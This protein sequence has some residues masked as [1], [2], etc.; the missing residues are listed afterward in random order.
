[1]SQRKS[2][3]NSFMVFLTPVSN[4]TID[5][6]AQEARNNVYGYRLYGF[7]GEEIATVENC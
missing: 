3:P 6:S 5:I 1:M 4:F 2:T 7:T